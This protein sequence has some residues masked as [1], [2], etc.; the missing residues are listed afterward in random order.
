[1]VEYVKNSAWKIPFEKLKKYRYPALI[2]ALGL[3]LLLLPTGEKSNASKQ[4]LQPDPQDTDTFDLSTFT[5]EAEALLSKIQGAGEV[6][7]LLTLDT[8]GQWD[9]L[10]DNTQSQGEGSSQTQSQAVL[11]TRDGDQYPVPVTRSYPRFRGAVV[12]CQGAD[13]PSLTLSLKE[14]LSSLTGLGMD[15]ITVL[16]SD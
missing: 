1:M 9:Y 7:L 4:D 14:A 12:L 3:L 11:V 15:K 5:R 6:K 13:S 10:A 2:L 8:D 16:K